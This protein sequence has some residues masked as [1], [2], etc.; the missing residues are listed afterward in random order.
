MKVCHL[1]R[2]GKVV[3]SKPST[4]GH[5]TI[6]SESLIPGHHTTLLFY[7]QTKSSWSKI[8]WRFIP[9][10]TSLNKSFL[11]L[12]GFLWLTESMTLEKSKI[13]T[14]VTKSLSLFTAKSLSFARP[15]T[16]EAKLSLLKDYACRKRSECVWPLCVLPVCMDYM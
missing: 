1:H 13:M 10:L 12:A 9:G 4:A 14:S 6:R 16:F 11:L 5:V 2:S 3:Y 15:F 8:Q 7:G